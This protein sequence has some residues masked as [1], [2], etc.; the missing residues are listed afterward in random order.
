MRRNIA[1]GVSVAIG[2]ILA[3]IATDTIKLGT[4]P[5]PSLSKSNGSQNRLRDQ[6]PDV[7][8]EQIETLRDLSASDPLRVYIGGDSLVGSFGLPLATAL[9]ESG[10]IKA[11]YDSRPSSGLVN[12]NFFNWNKQARSVLSQYDPE[13]FL[14][15]IGTNDAS[16]V[17]ANPKG[18]AEEYTQKLNDFLDIVSDEK[19][20]IFFVLAPAMRESALNKNLN[21]LND[22][23]YSVAQAR[24]ARTIE[25]GDTLSPSGTF[26]FSTKIKSK[27]VVLRTSDGVHVSTNGGKLLGSAILE[28]LNKLFSLSGYNVQPAIAPIKV[29]GCCKSPTNVPSGTASNS[30]TTTTVTQTTSTTSP[31]TETT[32]V[33]VPTSEPEDTP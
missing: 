12:S 29:P 20:K 25:S 19:R 15:M 31:A 26:L 4:G 8:G 27:S 2:L 11:T 32:G 21:K 9:G 1:I 14:F 28:I 3:L 17:S 23:I 18:Y 5:R 6:T 7:A 30:T 13:I 24:G 33:T 16:I 22:V 10:V